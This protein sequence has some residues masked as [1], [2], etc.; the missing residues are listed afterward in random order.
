MKLNSLYIENVKSFRD[1]TELDFNTDFNILI[2]PNGSG[3]SNLLDI[4][5]LCLKT[6]F[7]KP[8]SISDN[9]PGNAI[10]RK[11]ISQNHNIDQVRT[12]LEKNIQRPG[13][14]MKLV[15][16]FII[17]EDDLKNIQLLKDNSPLVTEI[18]DEFENSS[19][20]SHV[21][22]T[23][24]WN[25]DN[26]KAGSSVSYTIEDYVLLGDSTHQ[27]PFPGAPIGVANDHALSV[28]E[29]I[30][31][32]YLQFFEMA[33]ILFKD[34]DSIALKPNFLFFSPYRGM[35]SPESLQ[36]NLSQRSFNQALQEVHTWNSKSNT[37]LISIASIYF[38][39]KRR[40]YESQSAST[41]FDEAWKKDDEVLLMTEFLNRLGYDW[42][43]EL[44][45]PNRNIY[46]IT[47]L[48]D[49]QRLLLS[50]ASS[51][52]KEILNYLFGIFALNIKNGLIMIDEP[53]LH[54]HPRWQNL[55]LDLFFEISKL[56]GNQFIISTHSSIFIQERSLKHLVRL[57]KE[58][59]TSKALL[60]RDKSSLKIKD[61]L[62]IVNSTNNEKIF[63]ADLVILVEG[64]TDR[65]VFQKIVLEVV[66]ERKLLQV[67]EIVDIGGKNNH[68]KYSEFL[69]SLK[70]P[71]FFIADL[72]YIN[73]VGTPEI[74]GLFLVDKSKVDRFAMKN[75][76]SKDAPKLIDLLDEAILSGSTEELKLFVDYIKSFRTKLKPSLTPEEEA[77]LLKFALEQKKSN[78]FLLIQGDIEN[79][80]PEGYRKK[81]LD[82]V[83]VLLNEVNYD[84]WQKTEGF[85]ELKNLASEILLI[86]F[87]A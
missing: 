66:N 26:L 57:F 84:S 31:L 43:L 49:G 11:S 40:R 67:V 46:E 17:S 73:Q 6:Y 51:G 69:S 41:A 19:H 23:S 62:H 22:D 4:I 61:L 52:E 81:D 3:K 63:F 32:N 35:S 80:F 34:H 38:A 36:A 58:D 71:H 28:E 39:A 10:G 20:F 56:T 5:T 59:G 45:D 76:D 1:K 2:G 72:D 50:Q 87:P 33:L 68:G 12:E 21:Y 25:I 27:H 64:V 48:K 53:E 79:Y 29:E 42:K 13:D 47:L 75:P 55:L 60:L 77:L 9:M 82:N 15:F 8:A 78:V 14:P 70:V 86:A 65:I 44:K 37:S 18:L 16:K 83:I 54:L 7:L 85:K 24:S 30:I 74:K